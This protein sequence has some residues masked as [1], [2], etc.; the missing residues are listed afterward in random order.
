MKR[1]ESANSHFMSFLRNSFFHF[2]IFLIL[3]IRLIF[4]SRKGVVALCEKG[5]HISRKG[6]KR[7]EG[8]I[9]RNH[10]RSALRTI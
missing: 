6:M 8:G 2:F 1:L 10:R 9:G 7:E 5:G 3:I 4:L